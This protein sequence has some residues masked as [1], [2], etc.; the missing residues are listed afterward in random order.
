MTIPGNLC[1]DNI[2][3]VSFFPMLEHVF[4]QVCKFAHR[5]SGVI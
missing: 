5:Y 3:Y 2:N 1:L 4:W